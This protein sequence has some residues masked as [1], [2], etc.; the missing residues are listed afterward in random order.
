MSDP[1]PYR[2]H[3]P[4][5]GREREVNHAASRQD[6]ERLRIRPWDTPPLVSTD[7]EGRIYSVLAGN[8]QDQCQRILSVEV[9]DEGLEVGPAP[10]TDP[11]QV[12]AET[13]E[14]L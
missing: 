10:T 7:V 6:L 5:L 1:M 2:D 11:I 14:Q 12:V 3:P 4:E 9:R 13:R 8:E